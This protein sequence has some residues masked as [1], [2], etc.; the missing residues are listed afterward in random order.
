[1]IDKVQL[2]DNKN[3]LLVGKTRFSFWRFRT[4]SVDF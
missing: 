3:L 2:I 1:L 4:G